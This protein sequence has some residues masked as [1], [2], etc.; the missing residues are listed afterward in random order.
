MTA[1]KS[2]IRKLKQQLRKNNPAV[3]KKNK[4]AKTTYIK[5]SFSSAKKSTKI[6]EWNFKIGQLVLHKI[7]N[8]YMLVVRIDKINEG[9]LYYVMNENGSVIHVDPRNFVSI[10]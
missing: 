8:E 2:D 1:K 6:I 4:K 5:G 3:L 9:S 7:T 10:S